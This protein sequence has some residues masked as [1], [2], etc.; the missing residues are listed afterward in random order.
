MNNEISK[1]NIPNLIIVENQ[2]A[3]NIADLN[4]IEFPDT[5]QT[6]FSICYAVNGGYLTIGGRDPR[7]LA[8]DA[9]TIVVPYTN[10]GQYQINIHML[11]VFLIRSFVI[12][13]FL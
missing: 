9:K 3:P 8:P 6:A 2:Y 11:T 5:Y 12:Y 13:F 10:T 1:L 7:Y 4:A